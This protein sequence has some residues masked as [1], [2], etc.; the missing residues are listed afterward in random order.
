MTTETTLEADVEAAERAI[1]EAQ[2]KPSSNSLETVP[3]NEVSE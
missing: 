1:A 3:D 2:K